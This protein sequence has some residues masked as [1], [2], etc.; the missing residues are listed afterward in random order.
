M[1]MFKAL[2]KD[3]SPYVKFH[4]F[5]VEHLGTD[6]KGFNVSDVIITEK[7]SEVLDKYAKQWIKK[8]CYGFNEKYVDRTYAFHNLDISPSNAVKEG[9]DSGVIYVSKEWKKNQQNYNANN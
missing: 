2:K 8:Q 7:D 1:K 6:L 3:E 5:V 9:M 4:Q